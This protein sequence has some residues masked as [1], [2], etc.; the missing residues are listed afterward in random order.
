MVGSFDVGPI[1]KAI[2]PIFR[3]LWMISHD[4]VIASQAKQSMAA[5][6]AGLLRRFDEN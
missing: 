5:R 6:E 1:T 3:R 4:T 2:F